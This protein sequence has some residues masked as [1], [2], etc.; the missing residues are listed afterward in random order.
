MESTN[1]GSPTPIVSTGILKSDI[2]NPKKTT[3]VYILLDESFSSNQ[4]CTI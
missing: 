4:R 3:F 1:Y 2:E